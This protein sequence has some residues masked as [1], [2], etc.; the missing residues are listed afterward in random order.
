MPTLYDLLGLDLADESTRAALAVVAIT[1]AATLTTISLA[2]AVLYPQRPAVIPNPLQT[3]IP[4]LSEKEVA[5]LEYKPDSYPGARDVVTPYGNIRVYEWGPEDGKKVLFVHGISTSCMTVS[6]L[7]QAMVD[8]GYRVMMFDLFGRGFSDGV[9]DLPHDSRLY[10][11]QALLAMASSPLSWTGNNSLRLVGYS[12]GGGIAIQFASA[13]PHMVES[14]VLLAPAGLIRAENFGIVSRILFRSG[15]VPDRFISE[16]ARIRLR[17]PIASSVN[18]KKSPTPSP[19]GAGSPLAKPNG[20]VSAN[21]LRSALHHTKSQHKSMTD[22]GA[23]EGADPPTADAV[24]ALEKRV[25]DY[26]AWMA[27]HHAGFIHAFLSSLRHA[28][29]MDQHESWAKIGERPPGSTCILLARED[30]I[31]NPDDYRSDG[32]HLVGGEDRVTWKLVDGGHDFV[33]THSNQIM[34]EL[35]EFWGLEKKAT[36]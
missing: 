1:A 26:I 15:I 2:R 8:R 3:K 6:R 11:S 34:R 20:E 25:L 36:D 12:M 33:M 19:N 22:V 14:L 13:F 5:K 21:D 9:G 16:L 30:E 28:P 24:T 27:D 31:I 18:K 17:K 29:L 4:E 32:L 7:A 35:D 23:T 10:V